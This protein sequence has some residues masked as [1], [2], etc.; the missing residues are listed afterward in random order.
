MTRV[1]TPRSPPRTG[2]GR[3]LE[4]QTTR[5]ELEFRRGVEGRAAGN[6]PRG[7]RPFVPHWSDKFGP[8]T[9][10]WIVVDDRLFLRRDQLR[11]YTAMFDGERIELFDR[12]DVMQ[13]DAVAAQ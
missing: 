12:H 8:E 9:G 10:A 5:Q 7:R 13:I 3:R 2:N 4:G 11:C 6:A 1:L